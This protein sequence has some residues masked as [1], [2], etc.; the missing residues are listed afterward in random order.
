M[1][2]TERLTMML[3]GDGTSYQRMLAQAQTQTQTATNSMV[4]SLSS[5]SGGLGG[6]TAMFGMMGTSILGVLGIASAFSAVKSAFSLAAEFEQNEIAFSTMLQ[7]A[8]KGKTLVKELQKFASVTPMTTQDLLRASQTLLQFGKSAGVMEKNV[9]PLLK[10][11]GDVTG[12]N[13]QKFQMMS[14]AFGQMLGTG[15]LMGQ[16]MNQMINAGFNPMQEMARITGKS[17]AELMKM[18]EQRRKPG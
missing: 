7:S 9:V 12:G 16:D 14:L 10:T 18:R 3:L 1:N 13:S 17:T 8:E 4:R 11:I 5:L 15:R 6:A 2:E